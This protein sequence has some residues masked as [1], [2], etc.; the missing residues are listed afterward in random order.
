[1]FGFN[2]FHP[3]DIFPNQHIPTIEITDVHL[4]DR[5][6]HFSSHQSSTH[7]FILHHTENFLSF[8]F[9]ALDFTNPDRNLYTYMLEGVNPNWIPPSTN[10][11]VNYSNLA[12]GDYTFHVKGSNNDGVWSDEFTLHFQITPP[13]WNTTWFIF[14]MTVALLLSAYLFYRGRMHRISRLNQ[15]LE[16]EVSQRTNALQSERDFSHQIVSTCPIIICRIRL[17]GSCDFINSSG[18]ILTGYTA[19]NLEGKEWWEVFFQDGERQ[20][21][22]EIR[23]R[24]RGEEM[25]PCELALT[26]RNGQRRQVSWTFIKRFREDG[27][28]SHY[29]GFGVDLTEHKNA[30]AALRHSEEQFRLLYNHSPVMMDTM[31]EAGRIVSVSEFWLES[32]GYTREE[33]IGRPVTDFMTIDSRR[34]AADTVLPDLF[35]HGHCQEIPFQYLKK[36]GQVIDVLFSAILFPNF[37]G[38]DLIFLSV[39]NDVTERK[40]LE[41]RLR[42]S[43]KLEAVGQLAGGIAHDFNNLLTAIIGNLF[44]LEQNG[45][46]PRHDHV[47]SA[48]TAAERA[49]SL[50]NQLLDYSRKTEPKLEWLHL[51]PILQSSY[52]LFLR[53]LDKRIEMRLLLEETDPFVHADVAQVETCLMNLFVNAR[54]AIHQDI[55]HRLQQNLPLPTYS[56]EIESTLR[57]LSPQDC[58]ISEGAPGT[59]AVIRVA[60]NGIGID[61]A[62]QSRIFEPFFTTKEVGK[63]NGLGLSSVYGIMK[64]HNGWIQVESDVDQGAAFTLFFPIPASHPYPLAEPEGTEPIPRGVETI[65]IIDDEEMIVALS[66][67]ILEQHGYTVYTATNGR[68]GLLLYNQKYQQVD[69]VILDLSLPYLSGIE[70]LHR[71]RKIHPLAKVIISSGFAEDNPFWNLDAAGHAAYITKPFRPNELL[72][73]VRQILDQSTSPSPSP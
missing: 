57:S 65:L 70:V 21:A 15:L 16:S 43:Q 52:N 22:Q 25:G 30:E 14:T 64:Q 17:D 10:R 24:L 32:L 53:T 41:N 60:D 7:P 39:L 35:H 66:Q 42:H 49:S 20:K 63:G 11:S 55:H 26:T 34:L 8:T 27:A 12:P 3:Q 19:G 73:L 67:T 54:D 71:I 37:L 46:E 68:D 50:I 45:A 1:M 18:E 9:S 58:Q 69:L 4:F 44:L 28:L 72:Q 23:Q 33:V 5:P 61:P 29:L 36:N 2:A 13:F 40:Q 31:D 48:L 38:H 62:I 47:H 6:L 59:F 56:I 51:H